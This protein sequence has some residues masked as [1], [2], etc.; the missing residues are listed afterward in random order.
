MVLEWCKHTNTAIIDHELEISHASLTPSRVILRAVSG[1]AL[2]A[3]T[4]LG[5]TP[6]LDAT[7]ILDPKK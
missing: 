1:R 2:Y 3:K 7:P 6:R 4:R 5:V